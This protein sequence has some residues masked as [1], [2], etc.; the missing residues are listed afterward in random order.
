V[1]PAV[2]SILTALP[3]PGHQVGDYLLV[4]ELARGGM[5]VIYRALQLRLDRLVAL[6]MVLHG[7]FAQPGGLDRF[8]SEAH[9]IAQLH[10]PHLVSIFEVGEHRGL[11]FY[12]MEYLPLEPRDAARLLL[13]LA[14][15][16]EFAPSR[17][18][19]H[20]DLKPSNILLADDAPLGPASP[21]GSTPPP[22]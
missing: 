9:A 3:A 16:I 22:P 12:A 20:R 7:A 17:G 21:S 10:H 18:V 5:G 15:A 14:E 6:K 19:I 2:P 4:E 1:I 11:P 8:R 13:P